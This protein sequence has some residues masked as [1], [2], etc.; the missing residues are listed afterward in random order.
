[1]GIFDFLFWKSEK[2][3]KEKEKQKQTKEKLKRLQKEKQ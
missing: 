1:M 2:L 3:D